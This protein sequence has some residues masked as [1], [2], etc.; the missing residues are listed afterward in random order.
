MQVKMWIPSGKIIQVELADNFQILPNF[1]LR[2]I[3]NNKAR[4]TVK[5]EIPDERAWKL[6]RMMQ[7]TRYNFGSMTINSAYRTVT[8]NKTLEG[9]DPRSCHLRC[10]AF[11]W[12]WPSMTN[13]QR[14]AVTSWWRNLCTEFGEIGAIN[15][16][17]WGVHCEIGSDVRYGQK[18]FAIRNYR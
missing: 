16:Y 13:T 5:L 1:Q 2:E 18:G 8:F 17:S 14:S 10:W 12:S 15:Y 3:A 7:L 6:L 9:A 4:E 11:D